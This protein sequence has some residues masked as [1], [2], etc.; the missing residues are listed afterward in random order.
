M[1][2]LNNMDSL[3]KQIEEIAYSDETYRNVSLIGN[4]FNLMLDSQDELAAEIQDVIMSLKPAKDMALNIADRLEINRDKSEEIVREINS[5]ILKPIQAKIQELQTPNSSEQKEVAIEKTVPTYTSGPSKLEQAGQFTLEPKAP[6][7]HSP[8]Y[9]DTN[10]NREEIL[11]EIEDIQHPTMI[12]HLLTTPVN[13][14]QKV[15]DKKIVPEK[16]VIVDKK[17]N[18]PPKSYSADPYREPLA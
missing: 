10:L 3:K 4:K 8:Q 17:E 14:A 9:N 18:Q 12:D 6:A 2:N 5:L 1:G 11:K 15:E 13:N 7:S 16:K